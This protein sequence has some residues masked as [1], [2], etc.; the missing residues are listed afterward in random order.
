MMRDQ[1]AATP[2]QVAG[3]VV[4]MHERAPLGQWRDAMPAT[5]CRRPHGF[6]QLIT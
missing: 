4:A 2:Q 5:L 3:P 1:P 6:M